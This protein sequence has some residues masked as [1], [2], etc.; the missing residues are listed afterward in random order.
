M[1]AL[2]SCDVTRSGQ[3]FSHFW[4]HTVGSDHAVMA[5]RADWREQ[6][7]R[8]HDELGFRHARFHG[9]LDDDM[10]I[11]TGEGAWEVYSF[12]NA[13]SIVDFLLSIGMRPFFELGF[14]PAPWPPAT[15]P[16]STIAAM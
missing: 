12:F 11:L 6:M 13:D 1:V 10:S 8:A 2:F 15:K 7:R 9:L 16:C 4:E 3:Q 5:L 14:M